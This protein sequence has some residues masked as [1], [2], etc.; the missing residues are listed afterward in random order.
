MQAGGGR[1]GA[2]LLITPGGPRGS[3]QAREIQ[4][5]YG[6]ESRSLVFCLTFNGDLGP[7]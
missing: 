5:K 1:V 6:V 3:I 4:Q 2:G 7:R